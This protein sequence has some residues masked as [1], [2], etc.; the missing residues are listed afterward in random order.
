MSVRLPE[1]RFRGN[2]QNVRIPELHL[3]Q[4]LQGMQDTLTHYWEEEFYDGSGRY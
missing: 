3:G 4:T 2:L 1:V